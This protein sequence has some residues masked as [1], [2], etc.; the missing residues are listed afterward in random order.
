MCLVKK[1]VFALEL[2]SIK[3][4]NSN[5]AIHGTRAR[6]RSSHIPAR[7]AGIHKTRDLQLSSARS[8]GGHS[9]Q[10]AV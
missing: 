2:E 4:P 1:D 9:D 3:N 7:R 5:R 8:P 6:T 10:T